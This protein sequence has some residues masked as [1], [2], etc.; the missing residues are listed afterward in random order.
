MR[1]PRGVGKDQWSITPL[2]LEEPTTGP[3]VVDLMLTA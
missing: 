1:E 3:P 2:C